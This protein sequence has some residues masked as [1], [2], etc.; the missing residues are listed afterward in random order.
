MEMIRK[1]WA[2]S[3]AR[4]LKNREI[5]LTLY[6]EIVEDKTDKFTRDSLKKVVE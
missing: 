6:L 2:G 4:R 5:Q 1:G 3:E